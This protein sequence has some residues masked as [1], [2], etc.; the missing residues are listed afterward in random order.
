M[1]LDNKYTRW[2]YSIVNT[3]KNRTLI[4]YTEKHHIIPKCF[5]KSNS[6]WGILDG[7]SELANNKII[8]TIKEHYIAHL[9][10]TKM[11]ENKVQQAQMNLALERC[12]N[13]NNG[14]QKERYKVGAR[15]YQQIRKNV[16]KSTSFFML[17]NNNPMNDP[18][19][20]AKSKK[21][22]QIAM[23]RSE[24]KTNHINGLNSKSW[25][26]SRANRIGTKSPNVDKSTYLFI[27]KD[28]RLF[29]G[30]QMELRQTHNV[31][32]HVTDLIKGRVASTGGWELFYSPVASNKRYKNNNK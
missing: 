4:G 14:S 6:N 7:D 15:K 31:S 2:Y 9:L 30:T 25:K 1:Y 29:E 13:V 24:I 3:A 8:L 18:E 17:N 16:A 23:Q 19:V 26:D 32:T 10:L 21:N 5:Y 28:G 22:T 11:V 20:K 12:L 27:H